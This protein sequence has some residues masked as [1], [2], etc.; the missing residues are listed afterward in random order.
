MLDAGLCDC[1]RASPGELREA[2]V[3]MSGVRER[4]DDTHRGA[5]VGF[6]IQSALSGPSH[7]CLGPCTQHSPVQALTFPRQF[8]ASHWL[9]WAARVL[10]MYSVHISSFN[11]YLLSSFWMSGSASALEIGYK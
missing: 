11:T 5:D 9:L 3:E 6:R 7:C 8:L 1:M 2:Q 4:T 10:Y